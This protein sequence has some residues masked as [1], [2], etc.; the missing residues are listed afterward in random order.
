M[1]C[2]VGGQWRRSVDLCDMSIIF[3]S[4]CYGMN[5]LSASRWEKSPE[6]KK[7]N[8][9]MEEHNKCMRIKKF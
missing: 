2:I 4:E 8:K 5:V 6:K 1:F 7:L 9:E 3:L